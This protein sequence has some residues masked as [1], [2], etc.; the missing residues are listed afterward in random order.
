MATIL[1]IRHAYTGMPE[2]K[3]KPDSALSKKGEIQAK[4][5][6]TKIAQNYKFEVVYSSFYKRARQTAEVIA[7]LHHAEVRETEN[8]NEIGVWTSPTQLHSPKL[9]PAEYREELKVLAEAQSKAVEF[10]KDVSE[11]HTDET[12]AV[13]THG[14]MIRG[15]IA[16][17]LVAGVETVVRLKVNNASLSILEYEENGEF[18]RLTLFND[19]SHLEK[20]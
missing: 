5:L 15:I 16:A 3:Q 17:A 8:L 13:V 12:V 11:R 4:K 1:L 6:A 9:S 19:T 20:R 2:R 14:N 18:F 10:L 7:D